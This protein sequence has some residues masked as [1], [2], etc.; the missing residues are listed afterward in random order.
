[1]ATASQELSRWHVDDLRTV[2]GAR[3]RA[4]RTKRHYTQE[5][6]AHRAA[7]HWTYISDL[8]RGQQTPT[9]DVVNRL[10]RGLG[11][12]TLAEFFVSFDRAFSARRRRARSATGSPRPKATRRA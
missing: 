12:V 11:M 1:M 9:L 6:L 4:L 7:L 3:L 10:V 8:E 5:E 2:F